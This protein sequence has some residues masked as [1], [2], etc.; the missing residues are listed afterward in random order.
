MGINDPHLEEHSVSYVWMAYDNLFVFAQRSL[1][2]PL[3]EQIIGL[4]GFGLKPP[5]EEK[6]PA[7]KQ[8]ANQ[9]ADAK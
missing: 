1:I 8:G 7:K 2:L 3:V 5:V 9:N 4:A 6:T